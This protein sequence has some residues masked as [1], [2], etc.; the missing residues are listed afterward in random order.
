MVF[1]K[2][3]PCLAY[4]L[5]CYVNKTKRLNVLSV[6]QRIEAINEVIKAE[7][8]INDTEADNTNMFIKTLTPQQPVNA[9]SIAGLEEAYGWH[10]LF[11][12][13]DSGTT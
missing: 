8:Q 9:L 7:M 5:S 6:E 3:G 13:V 10:L 2:C 4:S 12:I 11:I 1:D